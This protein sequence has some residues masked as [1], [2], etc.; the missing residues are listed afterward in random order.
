MALNSKK[1]KMPNKIKPQLATLVNDFPDG[2][3]WS[4]EIKY[5]GY[6]LLSFI[7]HGKVHLYTRNN[8]DWTNK[9]PEIAHQL[10]KF[11]AKRLILDGELVALNKRG[12]SE[13]QLLQ[14]A[15]S[16]NKNTNIVYYVF[17][18]MYYDGYSLKSLSLNER[19]EF[20][21]QAWK[22]F[23]Q[24]L[25]Q[26]SESFQGK[27]KALLK[28]ACK[29]GFE[30][31]IAKNNESPYEEKRTKTWLK[32]KCKHEQEFIIVGY[33]P[34]LGSRQ[35][36]GALLIGY[37]DKHKRLQYA[38]RVG[39]GFN[40]DTLKEIYQKMQ[41]LK[42]KKSHFFEPNAI[43]QVKKVTWIKPILAA[44]IAFTEWTDDNRIR[45]PAFKG[46]RL[47]KPTKN[48]YKETPYDITRI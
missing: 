3:Q 13:F 34:P 24:P 42:T 28:A 25:I 20:L 40:E 36:F 41:K 32:L 46:L 12:I 1:S 27:A 2:K 15:I 18:I 37:Y 23:K 4:Y 35:Y 47:D 14:K 16:L 22:G 7:D 48:I 39:T 43:P 5:D 30:G 29:K 17:D 45:H 9:F 44:E 21:K 33:T 19:R 6:R 10:S 26:K 8:N 38:G 31:L 11:K